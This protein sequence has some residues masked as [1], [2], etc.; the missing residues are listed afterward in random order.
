[1][2]FS[3]IFGSSVHAIEYPEK[4]KNYTAQK[5]KEVFFVQVF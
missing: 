4:S 5:L 3:D 1:M 2:V